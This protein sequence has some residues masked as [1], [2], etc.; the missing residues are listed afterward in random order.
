VRTDLLGFVIEKNR[1]F[2]NVCLTLL[3]YSINKIGV[4]FLSLGVCQF[5]TLSYELMVI[6][7]GFGL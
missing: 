7:Y 5:W 3:N 4:K 2:S 6:G 1:P